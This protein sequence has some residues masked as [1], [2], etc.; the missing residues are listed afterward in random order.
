[1]HKPT[2][3]G[4]GEV[5]VARREHKTRLYL[6]HGWNNFGSSGRNVTEDIKDRD[7]DGDLLS[8][9]VAIDCDRHVDGDVLRC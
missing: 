1:M 8:I 6:L 7:L 3:I 9:L 5:D 4:W 2:K